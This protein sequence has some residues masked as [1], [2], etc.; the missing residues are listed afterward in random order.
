[1]HPNCK[2][3]VEN[4]N[5][6]WSPTQATH[7]PYNNA[8]AQSKGISFDE[9]YARRSVELSQWFAEVFGKE[10]IHTKIRCI[11]AGQHG[12][13]GRSDNHLR[14]IDNTFGPPKQYIYAT[15]TALYF[16]AALPHIS[17]ESVNDGMINDITTQIENT[18]S[19]AYRNNHI[20]K[21]QH[22]FASSKVACLCDYLSGDTTSALA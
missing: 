9:N 8:Q 11:L 7:G 12:Y 21:A 1:M 6:V 5:E 20:N 17:P 13:H 4:S 16:N 3:Y 2:I 22:G 15:S 14:Y 18:N 10:A 19:A